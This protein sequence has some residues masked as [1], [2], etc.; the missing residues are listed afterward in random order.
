MNHEQ[1]KKELMKNPKIRKAFENPPVAFEIARAIKEVRIKKGWTQERLAKAM[2]TSQPIIARA[3]AGNITPSHAF[4][5]RVAK[6]VGARLIPAYFDFSVTVST[7]KDEKSVT[8]A[9]Y[10]NGSI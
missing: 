8:D 6:A 4:L 3:E 5:K 1:L 7:F 10:H 9:T 2:K